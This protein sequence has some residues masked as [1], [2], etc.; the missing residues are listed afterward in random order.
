MDERECSWEKTSILR[1][2]NRM[3]AGGTTE[4]QE[5]F[6]LVFSKLAVTLGYW[7][8]ERERLQMLEPK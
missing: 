6:W 2:G 1:M 3:A 7:K 8:M 5:S 4:S